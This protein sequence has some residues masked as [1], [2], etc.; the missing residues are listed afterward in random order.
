MNGWFCVVT[1]VSASEIT[2]TKFVVEP[3]RCS[4]LRQVLYMASL[5]AE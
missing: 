5:L 4:F 1:L 3:I 2:V